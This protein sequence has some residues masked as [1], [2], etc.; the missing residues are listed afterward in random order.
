[1]YNHYILPLINESEW[2]LMVDMDEYMWSPQNIDLKKILVDCSNIGQIQV[3][4]TLFG[5]SGHLVQPDSIVSSFKKRGPRPTHEPGNRK[6]F[7]NCKFKFSSLNVH[8]ATFLDKEDEL[9]RFIVLDGPFVMNHYNCQSREFWDNI[10][11]KRGDSDCYRIRKKSEFDE[12]DI[13]S[14]EDSDLSTQN[15]PI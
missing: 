4:H 3:N 9:H 7:I 2:L 12:I 5:S 14:I 15:L 1:M 10:K 11:C 6:Y 8:H 13:N